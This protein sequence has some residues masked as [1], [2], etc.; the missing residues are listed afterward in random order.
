MKNL[1]HEIEG[2]VTNSQR[3]FIRQ[4]IFVIFLY[5]T[6]NICHLFVPD[7][8]YFYIFSQIFFVQKKILCNFFI[9]HKNNS[10]KAFTPADKVSWEEETFMVNIFFINSTCTIIIIITG[11]FAALRAAGLDWIIGPGTFWD[12]LD[13]LLHARIWY[14]CL[15]T[16][17]ILEGT[18]NL[19]L[20][21]GFARSM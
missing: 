12:V 9:Q 3:G 4:T 16:G 18:I 15:N 10:S 17:T 5:Q 20:T 13:V 2:L 19:N 14:C 8:Q 11:P 21:L 1:N 7:E 6:N